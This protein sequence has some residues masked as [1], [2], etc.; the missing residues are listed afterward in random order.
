MSCPLLVRWFRKTLDFLEEAFCFYGAEQ[1]TV[2]KAARILL[3]QSIQTAVMH[4]SGIFGRHPGRRRRCRSVFVA[5]SMLLHSCCRVLCAL[6][7]LCEHFIIHVYVV[8][9]FISILHSS[10]SLWNTLRCQTFWKNV[11]Y[12]WLSS[13]QVSWRTRSLARVGVF[14]LSNISVEVAN[15]CFHPC[16]SAGV[17]SAWRLCVSCLCIACNPV[18]YIY[19]YIS[20]GYPDEPS[21]A[22]KRLD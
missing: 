16:G 19:I 22:E 4:V 6:P 18:V 2:K 17:A 8:V 5:M 7:H 1:H 13:L 20:C 11:G 10:Y 21:Y 3:I 9:C 12:L 14:V 15:I